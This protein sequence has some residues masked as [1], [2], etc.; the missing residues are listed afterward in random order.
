[1]KVSCED[2]FG[3]LEYGDVSVWRPC[4]ATRHVR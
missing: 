2:L 1:M 3:I 4:F